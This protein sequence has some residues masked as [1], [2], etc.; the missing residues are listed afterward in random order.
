MAPLGASPPHLPIY[1]NRIWRDDGAKAIGHVLQ[2]EDPAPLYVVTD[3]EPAD[4]RE[5]YAWLANRLGVTLPPP[6]HAF[7][8]RG[9]SKR[10]R[11]RLLR[12]SGLTLDVPN[13]RT[14]YAQLLET[15]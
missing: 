13:Y 15:Q 1:G 11:N 8:A 2:L 9:G 14:G 3:D 6:T 10:C 4:L 7:H 5:V 12:D